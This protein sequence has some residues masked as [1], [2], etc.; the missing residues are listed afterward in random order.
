M[1]VNDSPSM[2]ILNLFQSERQQ[3]NFINENQYLS[4]YCKLIEKSNVTAFR[5]VY[6]NILHILSINY[7][8]CN[9]FNIHTSKFAPSEISEVL[10][11]IKS[12]RKRSK[13][14]NIII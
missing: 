1:I 9:K 7:I 8:E 6:S 3:S 14:I 13:K 2:A 10:L 12:Y 4:E 11:L 5:I